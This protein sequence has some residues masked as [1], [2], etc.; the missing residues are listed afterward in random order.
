MQVFNE[1]DEKFQNDV[2][3]MYFLVRN[4]IHLQHLNL[5]FM[6]TKSKNCVRNQSNQ[7]EW[8]LVKL[9]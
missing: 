6:C 4:N 8:L 5:K 3:G 7:A 1:F 9:K 2:D